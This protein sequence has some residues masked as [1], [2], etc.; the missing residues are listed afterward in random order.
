MLRQEK[1]EEREETKL[2]ER[3]LCRVVWWKWLL[4]FGSRYHVLVHELGKL[5][6]ILEVHLICF[7]KSDMSTFLLDLLFE[8]FILGH[9]S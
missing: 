1:G 4:V 6:N 5:F 9:T 3:N 2:I 7:P 8:G